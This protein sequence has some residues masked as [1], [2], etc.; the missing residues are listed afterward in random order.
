MSTAD[1]A[2]IPDWLADEYPFTPRTFR[3][4]AGARMSFLDAGLRSD[5]AVLML[6]GNPTWSFYYRH[7]VRSLTP[8][9]RCVV[10]DHVG[11]GLSEKPQHYDYRLATRI[12]D[13]EALVESLSLKR[14]HLV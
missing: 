11:M 8:T 13:I 2:S 6:H 12:A 1:V 9:L 3:T 4:P 7:L 10:P 14:L 5:E